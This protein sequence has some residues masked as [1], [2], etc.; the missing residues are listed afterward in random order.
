M[1]WENDRAENKNKER[2]FINRR[3]IYMYIKKYKYRI[4]DGVVQ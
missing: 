1:N 3:V 4:V 2:N